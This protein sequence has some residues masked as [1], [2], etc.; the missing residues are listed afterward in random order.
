MSQKVKHFMYHKYKYSKVFD[1]KEHS[2][3]NTF[4]GFLFLYFCSKTFL[5]LLTIAVVEV[6]K[7]SHKLR[8][9]LLKKALI[10]KEFWRSQ[11]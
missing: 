2:K 4:L 9:D 5:S 10:T 6:I 7:T 1:M 8:N 3:F 11:F